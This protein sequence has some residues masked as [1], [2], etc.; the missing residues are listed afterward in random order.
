MFSAAVNEHE[1]LAPLPRLRDPAQH[2]RAP[3]GVIQEAASQFDHSHASPSVSG[4]PHMRLKFCTACDAA[5]LS[6]L[7][8]TDT[9]TA[10]RPPCSSVYPISQRAVF[11]TFLSS[12]S[13]PAGRVRTNGAFSSAS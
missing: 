11:T 4:Y 12:G 13:C 1:L 3:R 7:S 2:L 10:R 8:M 9:I 6:R 5:P